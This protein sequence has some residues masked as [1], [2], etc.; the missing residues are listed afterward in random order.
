M[1]CF[2][3]PSFTLFPKNLTHT[4]IKRRFSC[5]V[6]PALSAPPHAPFYRCAA[7]DADAGG[8]EDLSVP[9]D[10]GHAFGH[11]VLPDTAV[12]TPL[13]T[14]QERQVSRPPPPP[15]SP[16]LK[17]SALTHCGSKRI[18]LCFSH[19]FSLPLRKQCQFSVGVC[20]R[21]LK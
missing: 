12:Q 6:Y 13:R 1:V 2:Y 14:H 9:A 3:V 18:M 11:P 21:T 4:P 19:A 16:F 15:S 10:G 5:S 20:D 17:I 7:G 8:E